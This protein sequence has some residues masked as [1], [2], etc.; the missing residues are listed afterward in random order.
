MYRYSNSKKIQDFE[1]NELHAVMNAT[2][3]VPKNQPLK[4]NITE[5]VFSKLGRS[6]SVDYKH[7]HKAARN[8]ESSQDHFK[9]HDP[10]QLGIYTLLSLSWFYIN[11]R[12][13]MQK[14]KICCLNLKFIEHAE[15]HSE[16]YTSD[17]N[18]DAASTDLL[19]KTT[20]LMLQRL[21]HGGR[22]RNRRLNRMKRNILNH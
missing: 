4:H 22:G 21:K 12:L 15:G 5:T 19:D 20:C 16:G 11:F 9:E 10:H 13:Q 14:S 6:L 3:A 7:K 8:S 1:D 17:K 18:T 2:F